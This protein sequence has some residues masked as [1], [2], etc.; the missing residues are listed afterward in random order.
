MRNLRLTNR[1]KWESWTSAQPRDLPN[2]SGDV[3]IEMPPGDVP[4]CQR[5]HLVAEIDGL[6]VAPR[7]PLRQLDAD[8]IKRRHGQA[9]PVD[10]LTIISRAFARE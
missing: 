5:C 7:P 3:G 6:A 1:P 8:D 9:S 10:R 4:E 2:P